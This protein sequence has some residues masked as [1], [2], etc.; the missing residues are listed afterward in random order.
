MHAKRDKSILLMLPYSTN[1]V[2]KN[3]LKNHFENDYTVLGTSFWN[4]RKP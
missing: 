3:H 2:N 4:R 1:V